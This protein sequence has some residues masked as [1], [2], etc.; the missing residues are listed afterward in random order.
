LKEKKLEKDDDILIEEIRGGSEKSFD[1]LMQNHQDQ[2]FRIAHSFS[3][4]TE[5]AMDITQNIFLKVYQNLNQFRS[6]SQFKTWL[7]RIA[8]NESLNWIK[9]NQKYQKHEDIELTMTNK[10]DPIS[11]EDEFLAQ[12]NRALLLKSLYELNTKYRL[13][14]V[15]RYF[16]NYSIRDIS[17]ILKCSEGVV[18]NILFRSLR[19]LKDNLSTI[20]AGE[21]R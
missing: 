16:E 17:G 19:K 10:Q 6:Q 9:K 8:F 21:M 14:V 7:M 11:Q 2:V 13:A 18:K 1:Q 15:L 3:K 5:N 20:D 4:D 12:E